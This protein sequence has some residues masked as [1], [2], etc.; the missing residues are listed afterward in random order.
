[1]SNFSNLNLNLENID[2]II[3]RKAKIIK[4]DSN[5]SRSTFNLSSCCSTKNCILIIH[6]KKDGTSSLQVQ[7]KDTSFGEEVCV[8]ITES[9][10]TFDINMINEPIIVSKEDFDFILAKMREKFD[11]NISEKDILGGIQYTFDKDKEHFVFKYYDKNSKLLLQG[12]PL[13][14]FSYIASLLEDK[15]YHIIDKVIN[16]EEIK[17]KIEIEKLN[18]LYESHLPLSHNKLNFTM[19]QLL[20]SSVVFIKI[21]ITLPE[22][23]LI[24][25]PSLRAIEHLLKLVLIKNDIEV[26]REFYMFAY[27]CDT[28][29]LKP[30]YKTKLTNP[31]VQSSVEKTYTFYNKHRNGLFHSSGDEAEIR[32]INTREEALDLLNE[33]FAIIEEL[34]NAI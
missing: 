30:E 9:T 28:F 34:S 25:Y 13:S 32:T 18:V 16:N 11:A 1:M 6:H 23:S 10:K 19:K 26:N 12:R 31:M 14:C 24:V 21:N 22:Y 20:K 29:V 3:Q 8:Y 27:S 15:D 7:G 33:T 2:N 4:K 5:S 17:A